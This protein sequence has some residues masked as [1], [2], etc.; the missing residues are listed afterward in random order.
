[1]TSRGL[2]TSGFLWGL[3]CIAPNEAVMGAVLGMMKVYG[4][5]QIGFEQIKIKPAEKNPLNVEAGKKSAA[6][7]AKAKGSARFDKRKPPAAVTAAFLKTVKVGERFQVARLLKAM[8]KAGH[9]S[10]SAPYAAINLLIK[11]KVIKR[12]GTGEYERLSNVTPIKK[13]AA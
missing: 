2:P 7:R 6:A 3:S 8:T 11:D 5:S 4:C 9:T 10:N 13:E 1:M 12:V